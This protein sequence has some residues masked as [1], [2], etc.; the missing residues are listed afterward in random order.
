MNFLHELNRDREPDLSCRS[1][2]H[3]GPA[4]SL[5]NSP[6]D[7]EG[8]LLSR[9]RERFVCCELLP[10]RTCRSEVLG[11]HWPET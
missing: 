2:E 9:V 10:G 4:N 7:G 5:L 1:L 3:P 6:K 11:P 8:G